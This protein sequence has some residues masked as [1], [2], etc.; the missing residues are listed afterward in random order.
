MSCRFTVAARHRVL[1]TP[2]ALR[3]IGAIFY[4]TAKYFQKQM[5]GSLRVKELGREAQELKRGER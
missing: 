5:Q 1:A 3:K 2:Y 4:K